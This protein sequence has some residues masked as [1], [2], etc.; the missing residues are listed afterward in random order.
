[1][2]AQIGVTFN[3]QVADQRYSG[4]VSWVSSLLRSYAYPSPSGSPS[5]GA[6]AANV[7]VHARSEV[8]VYTNYVDLLEIPVGGVIYRCTRVH[9]AVIWN[10]S[11]EALTVA[12]YTSDPWIS[13]LESGSSVKINP[14]GVLMFADTSEP[15]FAVAS[16]NCKLGF[17]VPGMVSGKEFEFAAVMTGAPL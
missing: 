14:G 10:D 1:M 7:F 12:P 2:S 13:W 5:P 15:G 17:T 16:G 4:Q 8:R 11:D 9:A 3:A 6:T